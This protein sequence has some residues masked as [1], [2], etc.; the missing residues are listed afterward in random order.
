M[1]RS[2]PS[3]VV[4]LALSVYLALLPGLARADAPFGSREEP[5]PPKRHLISGALEYAIVDAFFSE[6][7]QPGSKFEFQMRGA[8]AYRVL[9]GLELGGGVGY[10][11]G[12]HTR[13]FMPSFRLRPYLSPSENV[14]LG[15]N[16]A[17][18]MFLRPGSAGTPR[19]W[20]GEA[21][22]LGPDVRVWLGSRI[23]VEGS[24]DASEG[25]VHGSPSNFGVSTRDCFVA[26]GAQFGVVGR[27]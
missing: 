20:L 11:S 2:R 19:G 18:G 14:E 7:G 15:A 8:Y 25:C 13:G 22:S 3:Q 27:L 16:V 1:I 24:I 6:L 17:L 9:T 10:W 26:V 5:V 21:W 4:A 23:G 12:P